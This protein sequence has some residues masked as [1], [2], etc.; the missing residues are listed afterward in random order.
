M[1]KKILTIF[2]DMAFRYISL[3]ILLQLILLPLYILISLIYSLCYYIIYIT[4]VIKY[5]KRDWKEI[6][7]KQI[8]EYYNDYIQHT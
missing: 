1:I 5:G 6:I 3:P 8:N 2:T 4:G 7:N